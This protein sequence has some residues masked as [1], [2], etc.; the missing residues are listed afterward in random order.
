I[1]PDGSLRPIGFRF[2]PT[3]AQ[4][5]SDFLSKKIRGQLESNDIQ[6]VNLRDFTYAELT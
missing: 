3:D 5:I 1:Y 6:E 2:E 4:L